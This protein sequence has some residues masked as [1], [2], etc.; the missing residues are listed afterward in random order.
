MS[1]RQKIALVTGGSRGIGAGIARKLAEYGYDIALT[2]ATSE[3][4][5]EAV[6]ASIRQAYGRECLVLQASMEQ[7]DVP[8]QIVEQT[9]ARY[10]RLDLLVNNAGLTITGSVLDMPAD[11]LNYLINLNFRGYFLAAQAAT[12][13][14]RD[15]KIKGNVINITSSRGERAYPGDAIYGGLKAGMNRAIQS[16]ALDLAPYGI[17]INNVAPGATRVRDSQPSDRFY[18]GLAPRI[19][20]GRIGTPE[21]M[22]EAVAWLASDKASY[23]TGVTLRL[24]GGLILAGMPERFDGG[25]DESI[26]RYGWGYVHPKEDE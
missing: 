7:E 4:E 14:M 6:A 12:R 9:V 24:D 25:D 22:G 20:L 3:D 8:A 17:R 13:V 21:D 2:Y 5:A 26:E 16:M 11:K 19:P 10:G 1:D 18:D 15:Q 23:I